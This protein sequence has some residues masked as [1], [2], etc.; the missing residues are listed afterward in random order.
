MT[1]RVLFQGGEG[2]RSTL[3]VSLPGYD[4]VTA[5]LNGL[6]FDAE[7]TAFRVLTRGAHDQLARSSMPMR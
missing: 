3:K 5:P 4:V 7:A 2:V 6:A 1:R